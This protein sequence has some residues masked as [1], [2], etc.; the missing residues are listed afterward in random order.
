MVPTVGVRTEDEF[1]GITVNNREK[2]DSG[3]DFA[4]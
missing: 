2:L 1:S 3:L 4:D